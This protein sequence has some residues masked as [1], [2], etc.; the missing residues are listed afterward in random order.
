MVVIFV[1]LLCWGLRYFPYYPYTVNTIIAVGFIVIHCFYYNQRGA[2]R[3]SEETTIP[4]T[5]SMASTRQHRRSQINSYI[6]V[7]PVRHNKRTSHRRIPWVCINCF[8]TLCSHSTQ[9]IYWIIITFQHIKY[10]FMRALSRLCCTS[11]HF[12]LL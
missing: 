6:V 3:H 12:Q 2:R 4:S 11:F 7:R 5:M 1:G 10:K 8:H 9:G